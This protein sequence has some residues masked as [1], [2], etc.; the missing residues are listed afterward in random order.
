MADTKPKFVVNKTFKLDYLGKDWKDCFIL[1]EST[2]IRENNDFTRLKITSKSAKQ[3][4]EIILQFL[5]DHFI[6]GVGFDSNTKAVVPITK[7]DFDLLPSLVLEK[8]ILFLIGDA[9]Q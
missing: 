6:E 9:T 4:Q 3:Q 7:E 8:I 5:R 1:F 2:S